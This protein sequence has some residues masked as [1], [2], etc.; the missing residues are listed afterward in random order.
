MKHILLTIP[1]LLAHLV[2]GYR[3][4]ST[5]LSD[6]Y[7]VRNGYNLVD[8]ISC[9][10]YPN[11]CPDPATCP[12]LIP[13]YHF[14]SGLDHVYSTDANQVDPGFNFEGPAYYAAS[15]SFRD[16]ILIP[17]YSFSNADLHEHLYTIHADSPG[18]E[19]YNFDG[20]VG[21]VY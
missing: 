15:G 10:V 17:F 7:P 11:L 5:N 9:F 4:Y 20:V 6:E 18:L 14:S 1:L 13:V 21:G 8:T 19:D 2:H 3:Y 12:T 16:G